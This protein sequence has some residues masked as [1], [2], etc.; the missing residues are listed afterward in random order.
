MEAK[1]YYNADEIMK[2]NFFD[3]RE[4]KPEYYH[5]GVW[6]L[7]EKKD[8]MQIKI[9]FLGELVWINIQK[10]KIHLY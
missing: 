8:I 6:H 2:I 7:V 9:K 4:P 3:I 10:C 5:P 1:G